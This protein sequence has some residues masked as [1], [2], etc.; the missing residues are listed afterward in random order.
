MFNFFYYKQLF[1]DFIL[2]DNIYSSLVFT[3]YF[4][5]VIIEVIF[6]QRT[7]RLQIAAGYIT[8]ATNLV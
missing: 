5:Q 4:F 8:T 3:N 2:V 1:T 6:K 7:I